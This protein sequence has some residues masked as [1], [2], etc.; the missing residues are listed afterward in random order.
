MTSPS[1]KQTGRGEPIA[2]DLL[3]SGLRVLR[4][5]GQGV[6]CVADPFDGNV[7][8]ISAEPE[9]DAAILTAYRYPAEL[10]E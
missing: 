6:D 2:L 10:S 4:V 1:W 9:F 7:Y 8:V 3:P 5:D